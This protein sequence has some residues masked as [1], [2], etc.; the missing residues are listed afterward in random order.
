[1]GE[2]CQKGCIPFLLLLAFLPNMRDVMYRNWKD[3][4]LEMKYL[5]KDEL[6][7]LKQLRSN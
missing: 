2:N 6:D 1:M 5:S 4:E 3:V 7:L